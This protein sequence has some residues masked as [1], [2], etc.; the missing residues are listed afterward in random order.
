[1]SG[2]LF[3]LRNNREKESARRGGSSRTCVFRE[4]P[5][6]ASERKRPTEVGQ[7]Q[8]RISACG[9]FPR[10]PHRRCRGLGDGP[11]A[12][13]MREYVI[14]AKIANATIILD[15]NDNAG[16]ILRM[17][18]NIPITSIIPHATVLNIMIGTPTMMNSTK[19][20]P[21][22]VAKHLLSLLDG[23]SLLIL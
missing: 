22:M 23:F 16:T 3:C 11:A 20:F 4:P 2:I 5:Q 18:C 10:G 21:F 13:E 15:P 6:R 17:L 9:P 7:W 19:S 8:G 1:M 12:A 14:V